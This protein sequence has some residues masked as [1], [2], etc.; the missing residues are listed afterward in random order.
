MEKIINFFFGLYIYAYYY[1]IYSYVFLKNNFYF[2]LFIRKKLGYIRNI[3]GNNVL[4]YYYNGKVYNTVL[5]SHDIDEDSGEI[6][7]DKKVLAAVLT[8]VKHKYNGIKRVIECDVT[9][10]LNSYFGVIKSI[11]F[12]VY[13]FMML[14][15]IEL[16]TNDVN[17]ELIYN[18]G[19]NKKLG[20]CGYIE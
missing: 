7:E 17:L 9:K 6:I 13:D 5:K 14:N 1:L 16:I 18:N 8:Q 11:R 15:D 10:M 20:L 3:R 2:Y 4:K 12:S 19:E